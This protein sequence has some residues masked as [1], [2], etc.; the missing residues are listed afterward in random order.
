MN[1][2]LCGFFAVVIKNLALSPNALFFVVVAAPAVTIL[3]PLNENAP[4]YPKL[5]VGIPLY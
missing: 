5:P 4:T 2:S 1:S 3:F